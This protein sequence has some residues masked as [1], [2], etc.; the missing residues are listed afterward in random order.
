MPIFCPNC[1][2]KLQIPNPNFCSGCGLSLKKEAEIEEEPKKIG[3]SIQELG[4]MLEETVEKIYAAKGY[5]TERDK[6][7]KG[8]SGERHEIDIIAKKGSRICAIECKNYANPVGIEHVRNFHDKLMDISADWNG[9]FVSFS[10]FT[11]PA[12]NYA[13]KCNIQRMDRDELAVKFLAISV[14]RAAYA[15]QGST[16]TL[17]NAMPLK[18]DFS[19]ATKIDLKNK[20]KI[21]LAEKPVL[22]YHPYFV[23]LYSYYTKFKDPTRNVHTFKDAGEVFVDGLDAR[24]LN[25]PP[26]KALGTM[27]RTLKLIA[28]KKERKENQRN[29]KLF[30]ELRNRTS[31][32][33]YDI[34]VKQ[35][36]RVQNVEPVVNKRSIIKAAVEY[37][38]EK[39]IITV[40]YTTKEQEEKIIVVHKTVRH[41][42]KRSD[43]NIKSITLVRVPKWHITF[44]AVNKI[45]SRE[46]LAHSGTILEDTLKG[47]P[48]H[49]VL[50]KGSIAVCEICGQALCEEHVFQCPI[51][52][53]WLCEEHGAFCGNCGRLFCN[54]HIAT[55]CV[56]CGKP[57]CSD[58]KIICPICRQE[59]GKKHSVR[60]DECSREGCPNCAESRGLIRKKYI[61]KDCLK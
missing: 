16:I 39:N 7:I 24:V 37:I 13:E 23:V 44:E 17:E 5:K 34:T 46:R 41:V 49:R 59:Y 51:C 1:G 45:Y 22:S 19:E 36:Y 18:V 3:F 29:K 54:E 20:E 42:P 48:K 11:E 55:T 2:S 21:S 35:D 6:K 56:I 38:R 43:I 31:I 60:C 53:K 57:L 12:E 58:C 61:C 4:R 26:T 32:R 9:V 27:K 10:G 15:T 25:P 28:S 52:G 40:K 8:E 50:K 14:G 47:C 33:E 30:Q